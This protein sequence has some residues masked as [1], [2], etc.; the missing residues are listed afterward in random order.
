[1]LEIVKWPD[2]ILERKT[3]F[4]TNF[5]KKLQLL[6]NQMME[7][8]RA[9]NGVGLAAPQVGVS[10]SILVMDSVSGNFDCAMIN[11]QIV[12]ADGKLLNVKEGCLSFPDLEIPTQRFQTIEVDYFLPSGEPMKERFMGTRSVII[13][14][15][16][17][18]LEGR[19]FLEFTSEVT[20]RIIE[21]KLKG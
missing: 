5:D 8:M 21:R 10:K 2:P 4:V 3:D 9:S 6:V 20:R 15:E 18:H 7:T 13:Q 16:V 1:M 11:P 12:W 17:D 19:T 14:H